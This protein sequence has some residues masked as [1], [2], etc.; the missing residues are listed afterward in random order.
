M[1]PPRRHPKGSYTV[2]W[3]CALPKEQTAA[4]LMLD[5]KH[6]DLPKRE[7][8]P[9][10]YNLGSVGQH[11]VVIACLPKGTVGNNASA[12]TAT[13]LIS[14]FPSVKFALMVGIGAGVPPHVCLGD[15]VVSV[16]VGEY[17]GVVQWDF[18]KAMQD[19]VFKPTGHLDSPPNLLRTAFAN[20][21]SKI[22]INGSKIRNHL[23]KLKESVKKEAKQWNNFDSLKN[24]LYRADYSLQ[25]AK[26]TV[27]PGH[28]PIRVRVWDTHDGGEER[29]DR[30]PGEML[31]H[32][33]LI[34]SGNQVIREADSR[35]EI[36]KR[37]DY[38][39]LCFEMEAA[40]V[41]TS[42]PCMVIRGICDYA[43]SH[44]NKDCQE[45][46][47]A[48]AA[49]VAKELLEYVAASEV[50]EEPTATE[51]LHRDRLNPNLQALQ[52]ALIEIKILCARLN[53][54]LSNK[55][56]LIIKLKLELKKT[57]KGRIQARG[58]KKAKKWN[59]RYSRL[60][61]ELRT[62]EK[63]EDALWRRLDKAKAAR[64]KL[65]RRLDKA[66]QAAGDMN[67]GF[68]ERL[69]STAVPGGRG[70]RLTK[71]R[72]ASSDKPRI[73]IVRPRKTAQFV[74]ASGIHRL[75]K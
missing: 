25:T 29:E 19:K 6:A 57:Y 60:K 69:Q 2:G 46:A 7:N 24:I 51:I 40:G 54:R 15:V 31:I 21:E 33:G 63:E 64:Q 74:P 65:Q 32:Q 49:A 75:W 28:A 44:K 42:F 58:Y 4:L 3:V 22:P 30:T 50:D 27:Y 10:M 52:H 37:L 48:V 61:R 1:T 53:D 20:M 18:G 34:A 62:A 14:S 23:D 13:W 67:N 17:S 68:V 36:N 70:N 71:S 47:S 56:E 11:N 12:T 35:D 8:D 26:S 9:N 45:Y 66:K 73:Y 41:L 39:V 38:K 5:E 59:E 72:F 55:R 43:D 16:P